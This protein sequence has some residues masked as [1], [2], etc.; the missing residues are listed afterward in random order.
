MAGAALPRTYWLLWAGT[1]VNRLG[2]FVVVFLSLYLTKS[3]GLTVE[4][5]GLV[6][7]L[8]GAGSMLGGL[9]GGVLADRIGRRAT[10]LLALAGGSTAMV[11]LGLARELW[12]IAALAPLVSFLT[13]IHRPAVAAMVADL[14]PPPNRQRA[15]GL[16][17]WA[18]NLGFAV[19]S[20]VAGLLARIDYLILFI[21]DAATTAAYAAVVWRFIP[22]SRPTETPRETGGLLE[23]L[24]NRTFVLFLGLALMLALVFFQHMATLPLDM[25][26]HGHDEWAYGKV[27]AVN[28]LLIV[29]LQPAMTRA[30]AGFPRGPV[31]AAA[32][33][34]TGI[35]FGLYAVV[36]SVPL[37]ALGV[38]LWTLGEI[39]SSPLQSVIVADLAPPHARGRYQGLYTMTW[40][41]AFFLGPALGSW[42]LGRWSAPALWLGCVGLCLVTAVG[43]LA[44]GPRIAGERR[45]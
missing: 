25:G 19:A 14:V 1:L 16:L 3:R 9:T 28:G 8:Y 21:G 22:E 15:Y 42:V 2:S 43:Y 35:G 17:Y 38:A 30:L 18:I 29:L 45:N 26:A 6:V 5:A 39:A 41:L 40:G 44:L 36:S 7:S 27:V 13:D 31:L 11:A 33:A 24:A 12:L 32:T 23:A 34:A 20:V 10:L 37:Y 4:A